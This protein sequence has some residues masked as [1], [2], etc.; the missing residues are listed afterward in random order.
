MHPL[1]VTIYFIATVVALSFYS[2][3]T[4]PDPAKEYQPERFPL[5]VGSE[6]EI[7]DAAYEALL[8][9]YPYS[10]FMP[11]LTQQPG[12][13]W[14]TYWWDFNFSYD[15]SL[16]N[17]FELKLEESLGLTPEGS[18]ILGY[19]YSI[20]SYGRGYIN[21]ITELHHL[22]T[23]FRSELFKRGIE[24]IEVEEVIQ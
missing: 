10:L 5:V 15:R 17:Q 9:V 14:E 20:L 13:Y 2:C 8:E 3:A 6:E 24:T 4:S 1:K 16:N 22:D 11:L 7:L 21:D 18:I 12:F 23:V 19:R